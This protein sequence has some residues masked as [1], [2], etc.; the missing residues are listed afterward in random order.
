MTSEAN[1]KPNLVRV[2]GICI[3]SYSILLPAYPGVRKEISRQIRAWGREDGS[4]YVLRQAANQAPGG[5]SVT[6][7]SSRQ[8]CLYNLI[9]VAPLPM[10]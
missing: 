8:L 9:P 10:H 7:S 4:A 6:L 3:S 5:V 1:P 2:R